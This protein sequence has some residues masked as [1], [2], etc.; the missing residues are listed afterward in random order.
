MATI[1]E[2]LVQSSVVS[3]TGISNWDR[4]TASDDSKASFATVSNGNGNVIFELTNLSQTPTSIISA[5]I[6]HESTANAA[7]TTAVIQSE[8]LNSSNTQINTEFTSFN[9]TSDSVKSL[10]T[11]TSNALTSAAFTE[12]DINTLR[13]KFTYITE[14]GAVGDASVDHVYVR[15]KYNVP[16]PVGGLINLNSGL[17]KIDSGLIKIIA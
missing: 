14:A 6:I 13:V 3:S 1:T 7:G 2:D 5:Q 12:N 8:M 4:T 15:V 9:Q 11:Y 17:I 16:D 10:S